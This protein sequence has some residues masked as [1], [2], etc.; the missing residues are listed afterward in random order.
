[1]A[2]ERHDVVLLYAPPWDGPTR[3]SKHHLARFLA[4][5][6]ERAF[7][8]ADQ[9][10]YWVQYEPTR[11]VA[12]DIYV[13]PGVDPANEIAPS[14]ASFLTRF[15]RP[16]WSRAWSGCGAVDFFSPCRTTPLPRSRAPAQPTQSRSACPHP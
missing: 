9:F 2:P 15:T 5:R 8:G 11:A 4:D 3:F 13:L 12:P 14:G 16:R 1:M 7:V 6:G 10:I